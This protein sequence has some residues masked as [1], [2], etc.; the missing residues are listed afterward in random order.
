MTLVRIV[1]PIWASWSNR[2]LWSEGAKNSYWSRIK[3]TV[4]GCCRSTHKR[5]IWGCV[6]KSGSIN[7]KRISGLRCWST[8]LKTP[9]AVLYCRQFNVI[10]RKVVVSMWGMEEVSW[11]RVV[12]K[13]LTT[14]CFPVPPGPFMIAA[15]RSLVGSRR[16]FSKY[17]VNELRNKSNG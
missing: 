10:Q 16:R 2:N 13:A 7:V 1:F 11:W 6:N 3:K 4:K 14:R 5:C 9:S 17:L 12:R 8:P 15:F